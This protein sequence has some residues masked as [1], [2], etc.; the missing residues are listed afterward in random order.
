MSSKIRLSIDE[1]KLGTTCTHPISGEDGIL[2]LGA[3]T[4]ITEQVLNGLRERN[5]HVLE[6]DPR[7]LRSSKPAPRKRKKKPKS[8]EGVWGHAVPLKSMLVD[9]SGEGANLEH[10]KKVKLCYELSKQRFEVLQHRILDHN[11]KSVV[12]IKDLTMDY[13]REM[14][15]D[16]DQT[17]GVVGQLENDHPWATRST[18]LAITAMAMAIDLHLDG[19]QSVEVGLTG[20]LQSAGM[21]A[22]DAIFQRPV[23]EMTPDELWDFQKHPLFAARAIQEAVEVPHNISIAVQQIQEQFDGSGFPLGL[24][25]YRIHQYARIL[26]VAEAYVRLTSSSTARPALVPHDA[27]GFLLHQ[28]AKGVFDPKSIRALLNTQTLFPLGSLI[29]LNDGNQYEVVRR[30]RAGYANPIVVRDDGLRIDL[31]NSPLKIVRPIISDNAQETRLSRSE[32]SDRQWDALMG[33]GPNQPNL[34]VA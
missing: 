18:R 23:S 21:I 6:I 5:I 7:D 9:H 30:P 19:P 20:M 4:R 8:S 25:G 28:G 34:E 32:M 26:N 11:L 22:M 3:N 16:H 2:L 29:E 10:A 17:I 14:V 33:L 24:V 15:Q 13:A 1:I 12:G 27:M 31:E